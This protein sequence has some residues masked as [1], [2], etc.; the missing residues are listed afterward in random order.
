MLPGER[1]VRR[2]FAGKEGGRRR[3]ET[4]KAARRKVKRKGK[5]PAERGD[6]HLKKRRKVPFVCTHSLIFD[7]GEELHVTAA[8]I[9][10]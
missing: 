2:F 4:C 3:T 5:G 6:V 7:K 10:T 9:K 8:S 1:R